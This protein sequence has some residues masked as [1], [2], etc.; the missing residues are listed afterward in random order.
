MSL[1]IRTFFLGLK[2]QAK[3]LTNLEEYPIPII[4]IIFYSYFL[5]CDLFVN[6]T[7]SLKREYNTPPLDSKHALLLRISHLIPTFK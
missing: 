1:Y 2:F 6:L 5:M 3:R 7:I 4:Y